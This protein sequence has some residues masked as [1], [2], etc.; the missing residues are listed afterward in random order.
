MAW[1]L[2][3]GML[4]F[5]LMGVTDTLLMGHVGTAAQAGVGLAAILGYA[6]LAFFR[7]LTTGAQ[8]FDALGTVHLCALRGAGDNRFT[9]AVTASAKWG[10]LVPLTLAFGLGLGWGAPGAWLGITVEVAVL[11]AVTGWR[12]AGLR[13]GTVGRLDLLLGS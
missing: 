11:A 2:A 7:G 6:C 9:L 5:T 4:S 8:L 10:L 12:V 3:V 13:R 1:P